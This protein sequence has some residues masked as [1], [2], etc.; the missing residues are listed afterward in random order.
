MWTAQPKLAL[1][2]E[3]RAMSQVWSL[4]KSSCSIVLR[5]RYPVRNFLE[6]LT[7]SRASNSQSLA[8]SELDWSED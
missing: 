4:A 6:F 3:Q 8:E 2:L 5:A 7:T 1:V